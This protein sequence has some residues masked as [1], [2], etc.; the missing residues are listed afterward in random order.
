MVYAEWLRI[1]NV[2]RGYGYVLLAFFILA[3]VLRVYFNS[4]LDISHW[5]NEANAVGAH[6]TSQ[7]LPNG[8]VRTI[9]DNPGK[10]HEH[11]V[12]DD[13][14]WHGKHVTVTTGVPNA[15][16][17]AG[18]RH[19]ENSS[20]MAFGAITVKSSEDNT[21][22]TYDIDTEGQ[23]IDI[24]FVF[25]FSVIVGLIMA[26]IL[27]APLA[28]ENNDHLEVVFTKPI[29]RVRYALE[30]IASDFAAIVGAFLMT[31]IAALACMALFQLP[32]LTISGMGFMLGLVAVLASFAWYAMYIG[33]SSWMKRGRG[34]V[35]GLAWLAEII[36]HTFVNIPLGDSSLGQTV[37][38]LFFGL[39]TLNPI[40]YVNPD[41]HGTDTSA[42]TISSLGMFHLSVEST[43][44]VLAALTIAYLAAGIIEWQ[45]VEA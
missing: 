21:S 36:I 13:R 35:L 16:K 20:N 10:D 14:G 22:S 28:R 25:A 42:P 4:Q 18:H 5:S 43:A 6:V 23:P 30:V 34:A 3:V 38:A 27:G 29:S 31:V 9:I 12:I 7:T 32:M 39:A 24:G 37:H 17:A 40:A 26:T 2:L 1:R 44:L 19:I 15:A 33:I 41:L 11:I 8:T 45:R